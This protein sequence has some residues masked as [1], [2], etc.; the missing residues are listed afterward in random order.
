MQF[1]VSTH[2]Y[3]GA[4]LDRDHLVEI[5][6]H[7]FE[8]VE[9]YA[10]RT[11]FDYHDERAVIGVEGH[12]KDSRLRLHAVHAPTTES[13]R[14][15]VWGPSYSIAHGDESA[16]KHAVEETAAAIRAAAAHG[17]GEG[18]L[19]LWV[20]RAFVIDRDRLISSGRSNR[21]LVVQDDFG[22]FLHII[23]FVDKTFENHPPKRIHHT[24]IIKR[25]VRCIA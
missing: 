1:G 13:Y 25:A 14:D 3:H 20:K 12:L 7:G 6:A 8:S 15:G 9:I 24:D 16:R 11:H 22:K 18:R 23:Q 10:T 19:R 21:P 17:V 5:A 4:R 2:L